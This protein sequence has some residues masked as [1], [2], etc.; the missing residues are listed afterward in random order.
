MGVTH[1]FLNAKAGPIDRTFLT[2]VESHLHYANELLACIGAASVPVYETLERMN[3]RTWRTIFPLLEYHGIAPYA[4]DYL[5]RTGQL[6]L[7]PVDIQNA[8]AQAYEH[9]AARNMAVFAE[10]DRILAACAAESIP[11]IPLKGAYL[12]RSVYADPACRFL[13]DID[14]QVRLEHGQRVAAILRGLGYVSDWKGDAGWKRQ[15]VHPPP[16]Y[17]A[18]ALP[19]EVHMAIDSPNTNTHIN[20][21]EIWQRSYKDPERI[22]ACLAMDMEDLFLFLCNHILRSRFRVGLRHFLDFREIITNHKEDIHSF[23]LLK[24]ARKWNMDKILWTITSVIQDLFSI[25]VSLDMPAMPNKYV[26]T[27]FLIQGM[28]SRIFKQKPHYSTKALFDYIF[29]FSKPAHFCL[30]RHHNYHNF[31]KNRYYS[32]MSKRLIIS[33][34]NLFI[35]SISIPRQQ[36]S[37]FINN[38]KEFQFD[39]WIRS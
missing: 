37:E 25:S 26:L 10:L 14:I 16:F 17:K 33:F 28:K 21:E 7:A 19:V 13:G 4:Y 22:P 2:T 29:R 24:R 27:P 32:S 3:S 5:R 9:N 20:D 23:E 12:A 36:S 31:S 6:V 18:S 8:L 35:T 34:I 11:V 1:I 30:F 38:Y 15:Y 39:L